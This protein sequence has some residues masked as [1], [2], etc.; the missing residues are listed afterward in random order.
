MCRYADFLVRSTFDRSGR[1]LKYDPLTKKASVLYRGLAF[2]NGVALSQNNSFIL[3]AE[4]TRRRILKFNLE[5]EGKTKNNDPE[6]FAELPRVPD[7]IKRNEKGE[8]WVALNTGRLGMIQN[9]TPDP[10]GIK[11][12]QEGKIL[13]QLDG[14]GGITFNSISEVKEFNGTLYIGSV[15]K[16]YVSVLKA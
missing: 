14:N 13:K 8:F 7:N 12:D 2:P 3:V 15:T 16:P 5:S 9:D 4:S 11:Y 1:L 6:V 10:I